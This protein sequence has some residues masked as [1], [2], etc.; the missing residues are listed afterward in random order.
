MTPHW[1][2]IHTHMRKPC[3][4]SRSPWFTIVPFVHLCEV[5]AEANGPLAVMLL[6]SWTGYDAFRELRW[7]AH[8]GDRSVPLL[9]GLDRAGGGPVRR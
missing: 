9:V 1:L 7:L 5:L 4:T 8:F 3:S 6:A 2:S